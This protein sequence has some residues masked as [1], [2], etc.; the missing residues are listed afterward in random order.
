MTR[1]YERSDLGKTAI[2]CWLR[3]SH[4]RMVQT[5]MTSSATED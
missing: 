5:V 4:K 3:S 1:V 2:R